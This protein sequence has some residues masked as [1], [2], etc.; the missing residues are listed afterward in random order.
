M[1]IRACQVIVSTLAI[2]LLA[3]STL[4]AQLPSNG[5][6]I[7]GVVDPSGAAIA[8]ATVSLRDKATAAVQ[9]AKTNSSGEF[10]FRA[11]IPGT[12]D[13]TAEAG[14][15]QQLTVRD[16]VV[17]VGKT[18]EQHLKLAV[19]GSK[20]VV[21]VSAESPVLQ[22]GRSEIA[23]VIERKELDSLPL[24]TRDFSDLATLVPQVVRT[25]VI[26]P[27][28]QRV[29]NI[30]VAGTGGRQSNVYVDG[31]ENYDFVIG[32]LAYDVS[33]DAIQE[34]NVV[35]TRFTAEQARSMGA[36]INIVER[37][38]SNRLHG[39]GFFFFRNQD[40]SAL[41]Y[42]QTKQSEFHRYQW[43]GTIGG[44]VKKDR[45]FLFGAFEDHHERDTGIVNTN[46]IYPEFEGNFP[47]PFRRD[48]VT[49][50]ADYNIN[51]EH[52]L[53]FRFNL[54]DFK[55]AENVGG[56]RAFSNGRDDI[57][58]TSSNAG[59]ETWIISPNKVN[60]VGFQY[61][62]FNNLLQ[63]FS[64]P[65]PQFTRPDLIIGQ[66]TGDPQG[67]T[68]SR[69]QVRDDFVWSKGS[70]SVKI[71]GEFQHVNGS[72]F[73]DFATHGQFIF[74]TD[75]PLDAPDADILVQS[76]C[77][78]PGCEMGDLASQIV[79]L[80]I[81]DD[82][83]ALPNLTIN[84]G[85]RWDYFSNENN[86][87]FDG[88]LGLLAPPGSRHSNKKNFSPRIGFAYDPFKKGNFVVRGGYGIYYAN[89]NLLDGIV[90]RGFDGRNI[91]FR[92]F[93]N[94]GAINIADPFPGLT[95]EQIHDQFF[96]PPQDPLG[97]LDN[98]LRTPYVQYWSGGLQ[99]EVAKGYVLSMDGVHSLGLKGIL[100]RDINVDPNFNIAVPAAPLCQQFGM[101]VCSQFGATTW[102]S[103]GDTLNYNAF[104]V[105]LNK[106]FA[107]R[108]QF[109]TSYT[110]S[111]A[112]NLY[113]ETVGSGGDNLTNPFFYQFDKGAAVTDQRHRFI[114]SGVVDPS[115]VPP[116]FG[117]GWELAIISSYNTPLPYDITSSTQPDG[118]TP[119]RPN[120]IT[121][122]Q[123]N[124]ASQSVLLTDINAYRASAG[125]PLITR[126]L[127]PNNLDFRSTDLRLTKTIPLGER[128]RLRLQG[129]V[130][131]LLNSPN[132][133]S[134]SGHAG[135]GVSGIVGD[136]NSSSVGLPTS[137]PGVLGVGGPRAFQL[138]ARVTF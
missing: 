103:N 37:S 32:G 7:G 125:L 105:A 124:R 136:A 66:R 130:F 3:V 76:A 90:E 59:N 112:E 25:P 63:S 47:L 87:N 22:Q 114:F 74:F 115:R 100:S 79:G 6:V 54:D 51:N 69:S 40:L 102:I 19:S 41:D 33:P 119:V 101:V 94:P 39:S 88:I 138:S 85:V 34:F 92:V 60:N 95:P 71:G 77:N 72:A 45:L 110:L 137:T 98:N 83:K 122:N 58:R 86:K 61:F 57:T 50:K 106:S 89:I 118:I 35:T 128:F 78:T 48:F 14:G 4:H 96:G 121:R 68:E 29:G 11:V 70:H 9:T 10:A 38:G 42:F 117:N 131:N 13:L 80:Y 133:I 53:S 109:N 113:N 126:Q 65:S 15:F 27:T 134:N 93:F 84:A 108:L 30:S 67:T 18:S 73:I 8:G 44:P 116:F 127:T 12:Y 2:L 43:G 91:G 24:K 1:S 55:A 99:W 107:N 64:P 31:F 46:G 20:Q 104:I 23:Q 16:M 111:K 82:W 123:G 56:I 21:E 120:G 135:F 28:K 129:E 132:F 5:E 26:D 75:A 36:L 52:R 97:A 81:H 49:T 62:H 17:L